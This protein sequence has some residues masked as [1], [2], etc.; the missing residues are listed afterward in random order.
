MFRSWRK[1]QSEKREQ[2]RRANHETTREVRRRVAEVVGETVE[3]LIE[4]GA[5]RLEPP[6]GNSVLDSEGPLLQLVPTRDDATSVEI[7]AGSDWITLVLGRGYDHEMLVHPT[8]EWE[9]E[10]RLCIEAVVEGRYREIF[11]PGEP[12][13]PS[14]S[15][16]GS[17]SRGFDPKLEIDPGRRSL[18]M[19]FEHRDGSGMAMTHYGS[20]DGVEDRLPDGERRYASY[21]QC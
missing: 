5:A 18:T 4:L 11:T 12:D 13:A 9:W 19:L 20:L 17:V 16:G 14:S 21:V 3:S 2:R 15:V 1:R 10:L 6:D 8:Y 7:A